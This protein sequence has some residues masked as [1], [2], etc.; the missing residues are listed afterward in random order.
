MSERSEFT[1]DAGAKLLF[2]RQNWYSEPKT[3]VL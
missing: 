1:S 3:I 2:Q